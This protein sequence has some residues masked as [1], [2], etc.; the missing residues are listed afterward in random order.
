MYV[1]RNRGLGDAEAFTSSLASSI[2]RFEGYNI[3]GSVAQRNNNPGNLRAGPGQIGTDANGYAVFPDAATGY[4]ALDNQIDL[5]ISRGLTLN[6]F[7]AGEPGVYA[8]YAPSGDS[9][10]PSQYATTVAGWMGIDPNVPLST[11]AG[12]SASPAAAGAAPA[13]PSSPVASSD[14]GDGSDSGDDSAVTP[15]VGVPSTVLVGGAIAL[16]GLAAWW[17]LR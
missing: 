11:L 4:A 3:A 13:V 8:G 2:A 7:F 1:K 5:N 14:T 16:A 17:A 10:N 15:D 12:G 6:Q 9:N